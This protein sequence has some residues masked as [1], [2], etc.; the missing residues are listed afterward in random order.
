M[1]S[2]ALP[3]RTLTPALL[4]RTLELVLALVCILLRHARRR[5][6]RA[7]RTGGLAPCHAPAHSTRRLPCHPMRRR[8]R[9]GHASQ[10]Q[11]LDRRRNDLLLLPPLLPPPPLL[12]LLLLIMLLL[13]LL[14]EQAGRQ[15]R[16]G[17]QR[18]QRRQPHAQVPMVSR[19]WRW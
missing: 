17:G 7:I 8:D 1:V 15:A 16:C 5:A 4:R 13:Q 10:L 12:L 2:R 14:Q 6:I 3:R 11:C 19:K 18:A 9:D